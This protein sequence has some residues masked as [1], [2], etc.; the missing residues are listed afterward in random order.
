MI[1]KY[2]FEIIDVTPITNHNLSL[3]FL[4]TNNTDTLDKLANLN[5]GFSWL[6]WKLYSLNQNYCNNKQTFI[7][8]H[9]D[10]NL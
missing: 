3:E 10:R 9:L 5:Y 2:N 7:I 1:I 8:Y 4:I 6:S